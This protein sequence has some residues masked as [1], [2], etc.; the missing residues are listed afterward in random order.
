MAT[1]YV[2]HVEKIEVPK[3]TGIAGFLRSLE[4]VLRVPR[5]QEIK[6]DSK[7]KI[8]YRHLIPEDAQTAPIG[9]DFEDIMPYAVIRNAKIQ[10]VFNPGMSGA[11]VVLARL[12]D[13]VMR[14]RLHPLAF[15]GGAQTIFWKW[16]EVTVGI[17]PAE[18]DELF[19]LPF[20]I[21][22][23][24]EPEMLFLCAGYDRSAMLS[25]TQKSYKLLI[26][27]VPA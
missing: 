11:S 6:I 19:G 17:V 23:K 26:P 5:V 16:Y 4:T 14:D 9:I 1:N 10:E 12:F 3:N 8:Q 20:L 22:R 2:E 21:D 27:K 7:G 18:V 15:V 25:D 13:C 24:L